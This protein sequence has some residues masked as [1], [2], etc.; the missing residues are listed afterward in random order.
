MSRAVVISVLAILALAVIAALELY[1]HML[2]GIGSGGPVPLQ[3]IAPR[4]AETPVPARAARKKNPM[5]VAT[6][7]VPPSA[8]DTTRAPTTTPPPTM[9]TQTDSP[10]ILSVSL[11][12]SVAAGGQ[13]VTGTVQTSPG[14]TSVQASIAGYSS[15]LQKVSSGYF[16]LSYRVPSLPFFLH[17]TYTIQVT[18]QNASGQSVSSSLPITI[19]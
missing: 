3:S 1:S 2:S 5:P 18:A 12:S 15:A 8:S 19:R 10:K 16:A 14:V 4:Q 6:A 13:V 9:A 11:S 7:P 17:R